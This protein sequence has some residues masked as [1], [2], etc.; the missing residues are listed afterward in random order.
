MSI[1]TEADMFER[2]LQKLYHAE[3]EILDLNG[4][5]SEAAASEEIRELF[6]GH[7]E[8]TVAQITRIEE[9]FELAELPLEERG[10]PIMEGLLAEKDEFISEVE[11][12]ELRDLD[13]I[14]VGT[15]NERI[16][17][18]LLDRLVLL[19]ENLDHPES[20]VSRLEQNRSEAESALRKMQEFRERKRKH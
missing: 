2:E 1:R 18:T 4:D 15:I 3:L 19:A 14:G 17:I 20:V 12:D 11:S 16:E 10:S 5:L 6:A 7:R 9:I 8:D 13:A